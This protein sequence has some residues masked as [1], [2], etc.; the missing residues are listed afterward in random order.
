MSQVP[1]ITREGRNFRPTFIRSN[2]S[3]ASSHE[4]FDLDADPEEI[5]NLAGEPEYEAQLVE[6]RAKIEE[7]QYLTDDVWLF[8]DGASAITSQGYQN[9]G[10]KLPDRFDFDTK[11]PGNAVGPHWAP[12][13]RKEAGQEAG[14]DTTKLG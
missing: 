6:L 2:S 5:H 10:L 7:W 14:Q 13:Q 3:T 11:R 1:E 4:L 12:I 8:K 9:L